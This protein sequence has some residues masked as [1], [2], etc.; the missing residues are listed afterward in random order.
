[1]LAGLLL[2]AP[3]P[4]LPDWPQSASAQ[5][6]FT[7]LVYD[8]TSRWGDEVE[9]AV[10]RWDAALDYRGIS[11][12]YARQAAQSCESL[13]QPAAGI[14]VCDSETTHPDGWFAYGEHQGAWAVDGTIRV[15]GRV[16]FYDGPPH[17]ATAWLMCHE[18]GH[19]LQLHHVAE[20]TD[21]CMTEQ[22]GRSS[23]SAWDAANALS[24]IPQ[25]ENLVVYDHGQDWEAN[26]AERAKEKKEQRKAKKKEKKEQRKAEKKEKRDKNSTGKRD[27][28]DRKPRTPH[29]FKN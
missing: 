15:L 19:T 25:E 8:Y 11:L 26:D 7:I 4:I 1:V 28:H 6:S 16:S 22:P 17:I 2:F 18:L 23:P 9:N 29:E 20:N 27:K 13:V 24:Q 21:S 10:G 5:Q 12:S 3:W 14:V